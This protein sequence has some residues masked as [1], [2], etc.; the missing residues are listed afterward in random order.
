MAKRQTLD[1]QYPNAPLT[2][3]A[4]EVRFPGEIAVESS[5]ELF[6]NEVREQYPTIRVPNAQPGVAPA[7]QH[8]RYQH[9]D[10]SRSLAVA[11]NSLALSETK[12]STHQPLL[13][14]FE[15][16]HRVFSKCYPRITTINRIG[17]RYV[18][19]IP[20]VREKGFVPLDQYFKWDFAIAASVPKKFRAIQATFEIP[21]DKGIAVVRLVT[22]RDSRDE[23]KEAFLLD[24]DYCIEKPAAAF[25]DAPKLMK[26]L[27][28]LNRQVFE[29]LIT[30]QYRSYLRGDSL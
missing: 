14:E 21:S 20:F 30:D 10:G 12:Y 19:V 3:V 4:C 16:V 11:L 22:A 26:Q 13:K 8:Y 15:N 28:T 18:N 6:W 1:K 7:V 23:S 17:W 27:H 2:E 9:L 29:D 5:R 25:K 24:L